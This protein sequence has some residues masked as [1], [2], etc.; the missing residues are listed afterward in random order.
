MWCLLKGWKDMGWQGLPVAEMK[1]D[2]GGR[3]AQPGSLSAPAPRPCVRCHRSRSSRH[4]GVSAT[5]ADFGKKEIL[6]LN[7]LSLLP[8]RWGG[9]K[10]AVEREDNL[11]TNAP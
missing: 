2:R 4:W 7:T 3:Q 8:S 11:V 9:L 1:E 6:L 10:R 5:A